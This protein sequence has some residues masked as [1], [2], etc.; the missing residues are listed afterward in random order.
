MAT[1]DIM[2]SKS[3]ENR[4]LVLIFPVFPH[5]AY[6][7]A[8]SQAHPRVPSL[9]SSLCS[10]MG[11]SC[12]PCRSPTNLY[13]SSSLMSLKF[14]SQDWFSW[15]SS[16]H[17]SWQD[18]LPSRK[19]IT[20]ADIMDAVLFA[21]G[22]LVSRGLLFMTCCTGWRTCLLFLESQS[23]SASSTLLQLRAEPNRLTHKK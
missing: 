22:P 8:P 3:P 19:W 1:F 2:S 13:Q 11:P 16:L 5:W 6:P 21:L 18:S 9:G 17:T 14:P 15:L 4:K 23:F 20:E 10:L 7:H 12:V